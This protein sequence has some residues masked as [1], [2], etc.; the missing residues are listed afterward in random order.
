V[1]IAITGAF[2]LLQARQGRLP[3]L[4]PMFHYYRARSD[5]SALVSLS[6]LDGLQTAIRDGICPQRLHDQPITAA[7]ARTAPT[8]AAIK[9]AHA[10]AGVRFNPATGGLSG[11]F[12]FFRL[13]DHDRRNAWL[14]TLTSGWPIVLGFWQTPGYAAIHAGQHHHGRQLSPRAAIGHAVLVIG[15]RRGKGF[16]IVD[17]KGRRFAD[18]GTWWLADDLLETPLI[19]ESWFIKPSSKPSPV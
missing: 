9:A 16:H 8:D 14:A 19:Q 2:E 18:H 5:P 11:S 12:E 4:S 17:A 13:P 15:Y 6:I 10:S 3:E 7:G 1:S